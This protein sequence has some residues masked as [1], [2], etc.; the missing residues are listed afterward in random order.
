MKKLMI[1]FF[2]FF[3]IA[4]GEEKGFCLLLKIYEKCNTNAVKYH[5]LGQK[6][7][8]NQIALKYELLV[9]DFLQKKNRLPSSQIDDFAQ[10]LAVAC[11]AGCMN[12][13]RGFEILKKQCLKE[14]GKN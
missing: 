4:K 2:L 7:A 6:K 10:N 14:R 13:K 9:K 1:L 3:V 5:V 8:C 12:K 11:Y